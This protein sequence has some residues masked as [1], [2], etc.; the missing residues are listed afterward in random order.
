MDFRYSKNIEIE[1]KVT[2]QILLSD[3]ID[4]EDSDIVEKLNIYSVNN[5][6]ES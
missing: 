3:E 6:R 1:Y 5:N 2:S 4:E